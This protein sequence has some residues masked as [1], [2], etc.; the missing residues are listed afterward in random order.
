MRQ[1]FFTYV[2]SYKL[3]I[4][5]NHKPALR[6]IDE[7]MRR[8]LHLLP[9][10]LTLP[11]R[12][13]DKQLPAK[14]LAE[15][16]GILA[17]A[18]EGCLA[19]QRQGLMPP[20][21]VQEATDEYFEGEDALGRWL[22]E[23]CTRHADASALTAPLFNDW[24]KWAEAA[25]EFVGSQRRFSDLLLTRGLRKWRNAVGSRGFKGIGLRASPDDA[26]TPFGDR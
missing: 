24:K 5:G 13:R 12:E 15:R 11:P 23:C 4:A 7:A 10:T 9:F 16:D 22:E 1:D 20:P 21:C 6:N 17:W 25:G 19:W 14:L 8:R 26:F 18:L 2:P 3:V